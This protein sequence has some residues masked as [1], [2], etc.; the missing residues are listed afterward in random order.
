MINFF[1]KINTISIAFAVIFFIILFIAT[2]FFLNDWY[3]LECVLAFFVA[4]V[5]YL[6]AKTINV[7]L[8]QFK[9]VQFLK[10][11]FI[12]NSFRIGFLLSTIL[13]LVIKSPINVKAFV[14]LLVLSISYFL[15]L[16]VTER[17]FYTV[18]S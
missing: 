7:R 12:L 13:L 3:T 1:K 2:K 4:L 16:T 8:Q 9:E 17:S 6:S 11:F 14:F 10:A 5:N 15:I 18:K